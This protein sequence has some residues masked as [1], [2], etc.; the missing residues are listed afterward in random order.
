MK[1]NGAAN[2]AKK[3]RLFVNLDDMLRIDWAE[4]LALEDHLWDY[5]SHPL[6]A[7]YLR[8]PL[9]DLRFGPNTVSRHPP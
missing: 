4:K 3:L 8:Q 1:R 7:K 6:T 2:S 9:L 5:E